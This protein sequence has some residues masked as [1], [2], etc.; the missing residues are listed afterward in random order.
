LI[1]QDRSIFLRIVE[2]YTHESVRLDSAVWF[3]LLSVVLVIN[4]G[5]YLRENFTVFER[6]DRAAK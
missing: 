6:C 3:M 4:F 1:D 2:N 5:E